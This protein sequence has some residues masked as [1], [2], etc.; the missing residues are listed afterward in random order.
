MCN[1]TLTL[2]SF[3]PTDQAISEPKSLKSVQI[4]FHIALKV[5]SPPH[6][7]LFKTFPVLLGH[8]FIIG[9]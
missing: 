5:N 7:D 4:A 6:T 8:T 1:V 9:I 3:V 2:V